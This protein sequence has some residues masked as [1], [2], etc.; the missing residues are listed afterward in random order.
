[1]ILFMHEGHHDHE[2][3]HDHYH[4][5]DMGSGKEM[6]TLAALIAH[7]V[8][9]GEDH[10]DGYKEWAEKAMEHGREDVADEINEAIS[11]L[12]NAN[13]AFRRASELMKNA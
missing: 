3:G 10:I 11:M 1:M 12:E 8:H 2:H 4:D 13:E 5:G 9:H 6:K 7:W